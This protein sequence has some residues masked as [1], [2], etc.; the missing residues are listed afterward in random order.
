MTAKSERPSLLYMFSFILHLECRLLSGGDLYLGLRRIYS[1]VYT[2][3]HRVYYILLKHIHT[4]ILVVGLL[5]SHSVRLHLTVTN[6]AWD[7][8]QCLLI[9]FFNL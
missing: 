2:L 4:R 9:D 7:G 6:V 8:F 3:G 5:L 1:Q